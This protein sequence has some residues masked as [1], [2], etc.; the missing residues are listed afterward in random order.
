MMD[1]SQKIKLIRDIR[2]TSK[3]LPKHGIL[4]RNCI[5]VDT[6]E[7]IISGRLETLVKN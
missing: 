5:G 1:D 2:K 6:L 3:T 4:H 7:K